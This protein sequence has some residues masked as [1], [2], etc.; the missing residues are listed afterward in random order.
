VAED[1]AIQLGGFAAQALLG[2]Y[3]AD[4]HGDLAYLR[5]VK[6]TPDQDASLNK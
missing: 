5:P 1:V 2:D 6:V 3:D 4:E